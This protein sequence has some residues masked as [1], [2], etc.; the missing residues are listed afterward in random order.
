MMVLLATCLKIKFMSEVAIF[1]I[2]FNMATLNINKLSKHKKE[3]I[4]CQCVLKKLI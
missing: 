4:C 2:A 3:P 1:Y